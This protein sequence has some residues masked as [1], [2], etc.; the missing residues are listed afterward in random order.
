MTWSFHI[1]ST[2]CT[3]THHLWTAERLAGRSTFLQQVDSAA[4]SPQTVLQHVALSTGRL[5]CSTLSTNSTAAPF[6]RAADLIE[7]CPITLPHGEDYLPQCASTRH[8]LWCH[9]FATTGEIPAAHH[10]G[11]GNAGQPVAD[12]WSRKKHNDHKKHDK[13]LT[14]TYT[15]TPLTELLKKNTSIYDRLGGKK[16]LKSMLISHR[17]STHDQRQ[18]EG[19]AL[20]EVQL[21]TNRIKKFCQWTQKLR[22]ER[23]MWSRGLARCSCLYYTGCLHRFVDLGLNTIPPPGGRVSQ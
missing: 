7:S 19:L 4:K 23:I 3:K 1:W 20:R 10:H 13:R 8:P 11:A 17:A 5:A 18:R 9:V 14:K 12:W 2:P 21:P 15:S 22:K 6:I 16:I